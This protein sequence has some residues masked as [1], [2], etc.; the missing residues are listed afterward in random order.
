MRKLGTLIRVV[1]CLAIFSMPL[2]PAQAQTVDPTSITI[3]DG[4]PACN[5]DSQMQEVCITLPPDAIADKV[6]VFFL[7]DDTGSFAGFVPTV[8]AIF[9]GLVGDLETLLPGV[10]FGFGVGR[11]ED[12]GGPGNGFSS[13]SLGGRPFILNQPIVT[14]ADAG[15]PV[16]RDTLVASALGQ[17]APGFGGDA[18]E[19]GIAEGLYQVATGVGFDGD[20]DGLTT[21]VGGLQVAGAPATQTAPD[22]S[23]DVPAFATLDPGVISSGTVGGA[24]FR[25]D[26]LRLVILATD[27]CSISAFDPA[28]PIPATIIGTGSTEAVAEYACSSTTP[29]IARFGFVSD[30]LTS[31]GN[32]VPG[33]VV[34]LGAG[35]VPATVVALN[36]EGIRV[37]GMGPGAGPVMAGT[38]PSG[39][40]SVFLSAL[41]RTTGAV[42]DIGDPLV[43]D[44][45]APGG[46]AA[47]IVAAIEVTVTLPIDL[48]LMTDGG[49]PGDLSVG[50]FPSLMPDVAP[51]ETACFDVTFTGTA[52][53]MGMFDLDFKDDASA[54]VL[55]SIP[56]DVTCEV[57]T[58]EPPEVSCVEGVNPS[59]KNKPRAGQKSRG[60]N[61]DGFYQ[62]LA[63]D[64]VD[65]DPVIWISDA[66]GSG[67]FGP[68]SDGDNVKIIE[69]PGA[70]PGVRPMA[71]A[72]IARI[73]LTGDAIVSAIDAAGNQTDIT[74]LV[75][76]PP[77]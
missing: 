40:P 68:F 35:T 33:A 45:D 36:A 15:G 3:P 55:G 53:P 63:S 24:G 17:T 5:D 62:L 73:T 54:A 11:F 65:P 32:T 72:V 38:G 52:S 49:E 13:E 50:F 18:P 51:D 6:D 23:G 14:A 21:G 7:F 59:G 37:L 48:S 20:G 30:S 28:G 71:G 61:E 12:Y 69:A 39:D 64:D 25:S 44:I 75:P 4:D 8:S 57:L 16:A 77:K 2:A 74:C 47:E 41:A 29:G 67:P 34:P 66:N 31:A 70:T 9:S 27:I 43:F 10:E 26:A 1:A 22:D 60:Q 19:S 46:L 56:V 58:D 42:D 76:P